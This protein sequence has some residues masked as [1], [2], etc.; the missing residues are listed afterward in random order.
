MISEDGEMPY[1]KKAKRKPVS[2]ARHKHEYSPC[3]FEYDSIRFD[4]MH[5]IVP[6]PAVSIGAYCSVC[7]K[8]GS[9]ERSEWM[10]WVP[11]RKGGTAGRSEYTERAKRELNPSTRTLPTFRLDNGPF[12]KYVCL[13]V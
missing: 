7:G 13:K 10:R 9:L 3:V 6:T 1:K 5:G 2:K 4:D 8:V 12:Q 11:T